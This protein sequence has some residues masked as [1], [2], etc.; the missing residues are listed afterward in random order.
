V[1]CSA[2]DMQADAP[3]DQ[4]RAGKP[5]GRRGLRAL[6]RRRSTVAFLMTLPLLVLMLGLVAY[7]TGF[8]IWLSLLDRSMNRFVGFDNF[9]WLLGRERFWMVVW[10]TC[11]FAVVAVAVKAFLGFVAAHLVHNLPS[12]GQRKWR[13]MLLVPWV[14][15][16]A[17]SVLG[18]RLLFEPSFGA[19]NW[20][21]EHLG[22][23]RVLWLG[24]A[25]WARFSV[26]LVTVW[27]GAPFFLVMYLA[28]LKSVPEELYEAAAIDGAT[29]WQRIRYVTFPMMRN[30]IALTM[31]FSL[32]GSFA[33]FTIVAVLTNGGPLGTTQVLGTLAFLTGIMGGNLPMGAAVSLFMTP[34]LAAAAIY[35]LRGIARRGSDV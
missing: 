10:Q 24:E 2:I 11:L 14:I 13:G 33:G 4:Q 5:S 16:A 9:A 8:A 19:F 26:I 1:P 34:V 35:I 7:P 15:P 12:R 22:L 3:V 6:M 25:G 17:M 18:W 27:F 23:D 29:G 32:I 20:L 31:V 28:A 21:L 30:I